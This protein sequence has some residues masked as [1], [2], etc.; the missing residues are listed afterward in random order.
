ML[1]VPSPICS[2]RAYLLLMGR[3]ENRVLTLP[4][5]GDFSDE[6]EPDLIHDWSIRIVIGQWKGIWVMVINVNM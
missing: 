4:L 1:N 3:A 6:L 2:H 5:I